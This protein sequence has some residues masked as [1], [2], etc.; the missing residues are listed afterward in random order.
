MTVLDS[1]HHLNGR[2]AVLGSM[3]ADYTVR[4]QRLPQPGETVAGGQLEI[5]PGGKSSNQ[6]ATA[7]L[8]GAQVGMFGALGT[9]TNADFLA[10]KLAGAGVRTEHI[11]RMDGPSGTTVIT[12]AESDGENTIVYSP[13]ANHKLTVDYVRSHA[14]E[15]TSYS[16]LGL[17][18]ESPMDAVIEAARTARAAGM[19]VLLNDSPFMAH[20][21]VEL[22]ENVDIL[23]ANEH[24]VAQIIGLDPDIEWASADWSAIGQA[25]HKLGFDRAII[26]LGA[27]GS[28]VI[29]GETIERVDGVRVDAVDTTGCGDSYMGTVLAGLASDLSLADSA[30]LAAYVAAYAACGYGAQASYGT[31]QQI[32]E[33]FSL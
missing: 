10:S 28:C 3:N 23:L 24:E 32:Y 15:L 4:T 12:V 16:V 27:L 6:A 1:L 26:T 20:L 5:L 31:A 9:D 7:A 14:A 11:A 30:R 17:C 33:T 21:P 25:L 18:L 29:D 2:V 22:I 13:G 19:T 8:L